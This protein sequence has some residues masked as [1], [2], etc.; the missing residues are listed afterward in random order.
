MSDTELKS[1]PMQNYTLIE[2]EAQAEEDSSVSARMQRLEKQYAETGM[3]RSVEGVMVV[4]EHGFPHVLVLQVA[5]G[6]YKLPGGYLDPTE[7]DGEGL[8]ARMNEQLGV[9]LP[10]GGY[11][12]SKDGKDWTVGECLSIWWRPNFDT[13]SY[14]YLPAHVSFPK[15]CRKLYM[16]N[17]PVKKTLAIP[18][19]MKLIALPVYEFYDNA[20]RWG[21]QLAGLPYIMSK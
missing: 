18:A 13:F 3:R 15:E 4:M 20:S 17:L 12:R 9:P 10:D 16:V 6:F 21:P 8:L 19:N 14:P 5:N 1:Y 2:R 11:A 7:P